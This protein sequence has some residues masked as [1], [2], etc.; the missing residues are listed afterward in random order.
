MMKYPNY[1]FTVCV[2]ELLGFY[3]FL[4][5]VCCKIH[6]LPGE[7]INKMSVILEIHIDLQI[8]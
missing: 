2:N 5:G 3:Q 4:L 6:S 7:H 8:G 1:K